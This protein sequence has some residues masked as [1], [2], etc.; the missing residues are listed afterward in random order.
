MGIEQK[1]AFRQQTQTQTFGSVELQLIDDHI[2]LLTRLESM[3]PKIEIDG[4][5]RIRRGPC[6]K[7]SHGVEGNYLKTH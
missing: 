7:T 5:K 6:R 4:G 1:K 3:H 2:K